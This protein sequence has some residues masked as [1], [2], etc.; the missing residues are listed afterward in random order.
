M[1]KNERIDWKLKKKNV[2]S[3]NETLLQLNQFCV[4]LTTTWCKQQQLLNLLF[5]CLNLCINNYRSRRSVVGSVL[6]Y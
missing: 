3:F 2:F 6:V 5:L 1:F 4:P